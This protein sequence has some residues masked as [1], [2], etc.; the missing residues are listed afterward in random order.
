MYYYV[1]F[2]DGSFCHDLPPEDIVVCVSTLCIS[3]LLNFSTDIINFCLS[4]YVNLKTVRA[5]ALCLL[6]I[7]LLAIQQKSLDRELFFMH[8]YTRRSIEWC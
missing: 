3:P 5:V 2:E 7:D 6:E 8:F 4:F 1:V